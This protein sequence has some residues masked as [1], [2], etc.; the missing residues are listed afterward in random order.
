MIK[1]ILN[2]TWVKNRQNGGIYKNRQCD[3]YSTDNVAEYSP[4]EWRNIHRQSVG[5]T[6]FNLLKYI[7]EKDILNR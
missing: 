3:G 2:N 5:F 4:T 6:R 1:I 7:F